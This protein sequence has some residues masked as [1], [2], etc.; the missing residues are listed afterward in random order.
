MMDGAW[1][2]WR[3]QLRPQTLKARPASLL[4]TGARCAEVYAG[5][6]EGVRL[7]VMRQWG[8]RDTKG[9]ERLKDTPGRHIRQGG[10]YAPK[11]TMQH[12]ATAKRVSGERK[13]VS[14]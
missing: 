8:C 7:C 5:R 2:S 10:V 13:Q 4:I 14:E 1:V 3:V 9:R 11:L 6:W 12:E